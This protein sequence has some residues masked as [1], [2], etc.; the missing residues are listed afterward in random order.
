LISNTIIRSKKKYNYYSFVDKFYRLTNDL[1]LI[2][3]CIT[4]SI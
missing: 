1:K 2:I 3:K 4:S